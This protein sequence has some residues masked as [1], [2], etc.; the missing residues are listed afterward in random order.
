MTRKG[1]K[2]PEKTDTKGVPIDD[3]T[4]DDFG[5]V[6]DVPTEEVIDVEPTERPFQDGAFR[7]PEVGYATADALL[8][9]TQGQRPTDDV[10]LPGAGVWVK[11][12]AIARQEAIRVSETKGGSDREIKMVTWGMI[13]PSLSYQEAQTWHRS[14]V[15]GDAQ[16]LVE[17]ITEI[18]GLGEGARKAASRRFPEE[19][20]A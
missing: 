9:S 18:S 17:A 7:P 10:Y 8:T 20:G 11:I 14:A 12:E 16:V 3:E 15:A 6:D 19:S 4:N 5:E 1:G 13:E 2:G